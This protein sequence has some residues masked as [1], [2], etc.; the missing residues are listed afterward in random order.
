VAGITPDPNYHGRKLLRQLKSLREQAGM[1]Q[2]EAGQRA[3]IDFQKLSRI[4]QKQMPTYHELVILLDVYGVVSCDHYAYVELLE[5]AR[6]RGWWT[7]YGLQDARYVRM[8]DEASEKREF[9]FGLLPSLLQTAEYAR[10]VFNNSGK[11]YSRKK[12]QNLVDVRMRQQDRLFSDQ[13]LRLQAMVYEPTLRAGVDREQLLKVLELTELPNVSVQ[14][15]PETQRVMAGSCGSVV[16][17]SFADRDEP[18][19]A[20]TETILGL[21]EKQK[22]E[23]VSMVKRALNKLKL[24]ALSPQ[25][26]RDR[27]KGMI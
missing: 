11:L 16:V 6:I 23:D 14:I 3:H 9:Q 17:L 22:A 5:L 10:S 18:D 1:T 19:I 15:V 4:E 12:V 24:T 20:F 7:A 27:I 2:T 8:E 25:E 21:T 13:P 26:S